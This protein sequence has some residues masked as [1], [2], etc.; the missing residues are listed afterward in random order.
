MRRDS[1]SQND[2][3]QPQFEI[4]FLRSANNTSDEGEP[5]GDVRGHARVGQERLLERHRHPPPLGE[6]VPR[7]DAAV[8]E[9]DLSLSE[10]S[11]TYRQ[12][13][14]L[15]WSA[16]EESDF[17]R[18]RIRFGKNRSLAANLTHLA[19]VSSRGTT[20]YLDTTLYSDGTTIYYAI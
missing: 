19:F 20:S 12:R 7:L 16:S 17:K 3:N 6:R 8:A 9:P 18:Y 4:W 1:A 14:L 15:R 2:P 10:S 11:Y 13:A 5:E